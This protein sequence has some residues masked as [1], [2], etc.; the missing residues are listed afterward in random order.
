MAEKGVNYDVSIAAAE[1]MTATV[2][3]V[4]MSSAQITVSYDTHYNVS[5]EAIL[6]GQKNGSIAVEIYYG[7]LI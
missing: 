1:P 6:C 5:V 2:N 3:A 7:E 4:T